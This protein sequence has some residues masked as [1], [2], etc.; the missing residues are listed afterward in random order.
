MIRA[1]EQWGIAGTAIKDHWGTNKGRHRVL[2]FF[3]K[4]VMTKQDLRK[5]IILAV[6]RRER[7][8]K[9]IRLFRK[10]LRLFE[11]V[12]VLHIPQNVIRA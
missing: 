10:S 6:Y 3:D 8:G 11:T 12:F 1:T 9:E 4:G 2:E 7:W 5:P